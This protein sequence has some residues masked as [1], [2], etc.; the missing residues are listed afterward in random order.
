M[1]KLLIL[2]GLPASGKSTYAKELVNKGWKRVNKDLLREMLDNGKWSR[3]N[4]KSI[5]ESEKL[6]VEY[7]LKRGEN[8][9]IDDCNFAWEDTWKAIGEKVFAEVEVKLFDTPL[10][11]CIERDAKR[12]DKAEI[13]Y[14]VSAVT[15]LGGIVG[16]INIEDK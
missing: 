13:I 7:F 11:E 3:M 9:V 15:G 1:N 12:G 6:L 8:V 14:G 2:K 4:E 10:M 5:V 16:W